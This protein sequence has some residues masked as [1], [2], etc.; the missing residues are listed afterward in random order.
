MLLRTS[1]NLI[2]SGWYRGVYFGR[3]DLEDPFFHHV[4]STLH[5]FSENFFIFRYRSVYLEEELRG[6]GEDGI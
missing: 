1:R 4:V 3:I 2:E 6:E 5:E